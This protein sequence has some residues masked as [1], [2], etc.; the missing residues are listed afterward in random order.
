MFTVA[1]SWQLYQLTH[2]ATALGLLGV[3]RLIPI[4]F[5]ALPGGAFADRHNRKHI[6]YVTQPVIALSSLALA[7]ATATHHIT[8]LLLYLLVAVV[9]AAVSYDLPARSAMLPN[10]VAPEQLGNALGVY[11]VLWQASD[12]VGPAIAGF[13]IAG[14]G[15]GAVYTLDGLSTVAVIV[16]LLRMTHSGAPV[17]TTAVTDLPPLTAL[18]EGL[19]FIATTPLLWSTLLL[20]FLSTLFASVTALLPVYAIAILHVGPQ[21]LGA[22]YAAPSLGALLVSST[23]ALWGPHIRRHGVALFAAIA[24]YAAATILFGVSR[25]LVVSLVTLAVVGASDAISMLLRQTLRVRLTPDHVRGRM[26]SVHMLS[27]MGGEQLGN[28]EGGLLAGAIGAPLAVVAGGVGTLIT[29]ALVATTIPALRRY[30]D[31]L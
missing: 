11:E 19:R 22:L 27:V 17:N 31:V 13:V 6:L 28:L 20:D 21:G 4:I 2:S 29:L 15:V 5:G 9:G 18:R 3:A 30:R 8:P 10:L 16:A 23:Y 12:L 7:L 25:V 1:V 26:S 14:L 24:T